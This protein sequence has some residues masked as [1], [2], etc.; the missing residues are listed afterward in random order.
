MKYNKNEVITKTKE[1][2][3]RMQDYLTE[4]CRICVFIR[5]R[6]AENQNNPITRDVEF[7]A[8]LNRTVDDCKTALDNLNNLNKS[9]NQ[10]ISVDN[11]ADAVAPIGHMQIE[12]DHM[13]CDLDV[14]DFDMQYRRKCERIQQNFNMIFIIVDDMEDFLYEVYPDA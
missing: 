7:I 6:D 1:Y 2:I 11:M 12:I 4:I 8:A 3:E 5:L 13:Y 9:P 14:E 10:F